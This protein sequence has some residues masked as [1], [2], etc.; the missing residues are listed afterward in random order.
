MLN[1][2]FNNIIIL[3]CDICKN[4]FNAALHNASVFQVKLCFQN[5]K[6]RLKNCFYIFILMF[7]IT[8]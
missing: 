5:Q 6:F 8:L 3:E 4:Y 7:F 1:I 2:S